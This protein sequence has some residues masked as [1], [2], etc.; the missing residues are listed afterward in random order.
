MKLKAK[1]RIVQFIDFKKITKNK[2]CE[3]NLFSNSFFNNDSAISSD[4]LLNI[5]RNYPELNMDWVITGR[6]EMITKTTEKDLAIIQA[7]EPK[8]L[9]KTDKD[10]LIE[11]LQKSI[12]DK[13]K[14]IA[15]LEGKVLPKTK[16]ATALH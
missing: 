3:K 16:S 5:F 10:L 7:A 2:F 15:L 6:G 9:Y 11:T 1:E 8:A 4:K 12:E 13:E 14:I